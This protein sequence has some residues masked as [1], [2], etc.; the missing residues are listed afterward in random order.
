[1]KTLYTNDYLCLPSL[2][3]DAGYRTEMVIGQNRDRGHEHIGL[4]LARN[5]LQQ[6]FDEQVFQGKNQRMGIG[7]TDGAL[8]DFLQTRI[9]TLRQEGKPYFLSAL[10]NSTHH[11]FEVP[12][13]HS[14]VRALEDQDDQYLKALRYVD[15]ELER[16]FSELR[17][18][19]LLKKYRGLYSGRPWPA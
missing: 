7:I 14:D 18:E 15:L 13:E 6:L 3:R 9:R 5:G 1:M 11:P 2:L 17:R 8:F 10:T 12:L 19:D 16:F 4:F